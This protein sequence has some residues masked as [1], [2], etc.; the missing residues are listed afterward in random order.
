MLYKQRVVQQRAHRMQA[1]YFSTMIRCSLRRHRSGA[2][3][4]CDAGCR[5]VSRRHV[6]DLSQPREA[7]FTVV[8]GRGSTSEVLDDHKAFLFDAQRQLVTLPLTYYTD[9][10]PSYGSRTFMVRRA[11]GV[12]LVRC[13]CARLTHHVECQ[14]SGCLGVPAIT[15]IVRCGGWHNPCG[16]WRLASAERVCVWLLVRAACASVAL[17][18]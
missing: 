13:A 1:F 10:F 4:Q 14:C 5:T 15:I 8:G 6:G 9:M 2:Q 18:R 11:G 3:L 7:Y 17:H 12:P 16:W